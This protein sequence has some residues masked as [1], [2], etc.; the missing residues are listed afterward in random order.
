MLS[1]MRY[2]L[3]A[4]TNT[5]QM[6]PRQSQI[7]MRHYNKAKGSSPFIKYALTDDVT[8]WYVLF[9]GIG[10]DGGP[11]Q[12]Y[13]GGEYL[14]RLEIPPG[15][16]TE[17]PN[18]YVLTPN[19]L[20]DILDKVCVSVSEFHSNSYPPTSGI[21]GFCEYLLSGLLTWQDMGKGIRLL[22]TTSEEK[23]ALAVASKAYN[24]THYADKLALFE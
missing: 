24:I 1:I 21:T 20:Y 11:G 16:P 3:P 23:Q 7:I 10:A 13:I 2:I 9:H 14:M 18:F 6:Q 19:G 15:F 8:V 22:E 4:A 5:N 12:E 17:P